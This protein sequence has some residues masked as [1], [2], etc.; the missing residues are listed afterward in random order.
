MHDGNRGQKKKRMDTVSLDGTII[1]INYEEN[2]QQ[3]NCIQ[4]IL[5]HT[6]RHTHTICYT[7]QQQAT[8]HYARPEAS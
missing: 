7:T 1:I 5:Y 8:R 3:P 2:R 6:T 4:Y